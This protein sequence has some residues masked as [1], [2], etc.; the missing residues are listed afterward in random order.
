MLL[1]EG[2]VVVLAAE[3]PLGVGPLKVVNEGIFRLGVRRSLPERYRLLLA[4]AMPE[5]TVRET[6]AEYAPSLE[7]AVAEARRST[8]AGARWLVLP[9]GGDLVPVVEP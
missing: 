5:A 9:D 2:G 8:G 3:C 6:Y 7:A 4:S 1:R